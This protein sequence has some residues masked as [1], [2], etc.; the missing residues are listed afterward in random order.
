MQKDAEIDCAGMVEQLYWSR[1][2]IRFQTKWW[3]GRCRRG[4][5]A[6]LVRIEPEEVAWLTL[7]RGAKFAEGREAGINGAFAYLK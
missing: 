1:E 2:T 3:P 6:I 4:L 7:E 5:L